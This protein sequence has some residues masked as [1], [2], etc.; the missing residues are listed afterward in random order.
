VGGFL[1]EEN[2]FFA[3]EGTRRFTTF[4]SSSTRT[5]TSTFRGAYTVGRTEA[6][7][8]GVYSTSIKFETTTFSQSYSGL[9]KTVGY[10][11]ST[12]VSY[13]TFVSP[14]VPASRTARTTTT[15]TVS[16]PHSRFVSFHTALF[17]AD[18]RA[19]VWLRLNTQTGRAGVFVG[20]EATDVFVGDYTLITEPFY[21][22]TSH[23]S[24]VALVLD[25]GLISWSSFQNERIPAYAFTADSIDW[26][27]TYDVGTGITP[28]SWVTTFSE[29]R[30]VP[31]FREFTVGGDAD[32]E[33]HVGHFDGHTGT[34]TESLPWGT[35][36]LV[37]EPVALA[38]GVSAVR[39]Y[40]HTTTTQRRVTLRDY[41]TT[42]STSTASS[43]TTRFS[44]VAAGSTRFLYQRTRFGQVN[45]FNVDDTPPVVLN[46]VNLG[47]VQAPDMRIGDG[48]RYLQATFS[49]APDQY[50][51][52]ERP[53]VIAPLL[54]TDSPTAVTV[55]PPATE[56][57]F[58]WGTVSV[59]IDDKPA[60]WGA[61]AITPVGVYLT[62]T[63]NDV[64][65]RGPT[66]MGSTYYD[67]SGQ[68]VTVLTGAR[69]VWERVGYREWVT[70]TGTSGVDVGLD[71]L[72]T[73]SPR[74]YNNTA[75]FF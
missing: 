70:F 7:S 17:A 46:R 38:P 39:Q 48:A 4:E 61:T 72:T 27:T 60:V 40:I 64:S 29:E 24:V 68:T 73:F 6:L 25:Q 49:P 74:Y 51:F 63:Y 26:T 65:E 47:G 13:T 42:M 57:A 9:D 11:A 75:E 1:N 66:S 15:S 41:V 55:G 12:T 37:L 62:A 23:S 19:A 44:S 14:G 54:D 34:T 30:A 16:Y 53:A 21:E 59:G 28:G 8:R 67:P 36:R 35:T 22:T 71:R 10:V 32:T 69:T 18:W 43:N 31:I 3:Q 5:R 58:K 56:T 52:A 2:G 33:T 20:S 45:A 50:A